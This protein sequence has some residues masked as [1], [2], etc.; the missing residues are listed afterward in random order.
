MPSGSRPPPKPPES[1]RIDYLLVTHY[2]SD[3]VG[4][5][6][7]L[8]ELFKVSNVLDYGPSVDA[9]GKYPEDYSAAIARIPSH[10]VVKPG[11]KIPIK[12]LDVTV[13]TA[14]GK[15]MD[16]PGIPNPYCSGIERHPEGS[17]DETGENPQAVGVVIELGKFRFGDFSDAPLRVPL[18]SQ[19]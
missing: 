2:H 12:G 8:L 19:Q 10:R 3:H 5:V 6:P 9:G 7:N 14:A 13:L 11:D 15:H 4:G 1:R 17:V 16:G 18:N